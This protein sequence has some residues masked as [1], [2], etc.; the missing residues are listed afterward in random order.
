MRPFSRKRMAA[1]MPALLGVASLIAFGQ[2]GQPSPDQSQPAQSQSSEQQPMQMK[3]MSA[4]SELLSKMHMA[5]QME[6]K[7][8]QLAES[9]GTTPAIRTYG[10]LLVRD[11]SYADK[12]ITDLAKQQGIQ[13]MQTPMPNSPDEKQKMDMQKQMM[14]GLEQAQGADFDR[15]FIEFNVKA[16]EMAV[17]MVSM[18]S[19]QLK[20]SPVKTLASK[21]V[22]ILKQHGDIAQHLEQRQVASR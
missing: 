10:Q 2:Q 21:M 14:A 16:H 17:N 20:P 7:A 1:L 4:E 13:L 6:I 8:G 19:Q 11:H 9:K 15:Q 3:S 22:P 18:G 5:N 12:R